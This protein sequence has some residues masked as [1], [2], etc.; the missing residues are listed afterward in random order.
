M[1]VDLGEALEGFT[2]TEKSISIPFDVLE[3]WSVVLRNIPQF[4]VDSFH[5]D[6]R[7]SPHDHSEGKHVTFV[8]NTVMS[9]IPDLCYKYMSLATSVSY[10]ELGFEGNLGILFEFYDPAQNLGWESTYNNVGECVQKKECHYIRGLLNLRQ[11]Q[12]VTLYPTPYPAKYH[13]YIKLQ[14]TQDTDRC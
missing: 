1:Q 6:F 12:V 13:S 3:V 14:Y 4:S 11:R 8:D 7:R 5:V 9:L 2:S 10:Y